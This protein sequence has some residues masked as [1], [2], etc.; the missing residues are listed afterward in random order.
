[1]ATPYQI[2]SGDTL[3]AIAQTNKTDLPTLL[4]LN[5]NIKDP[6]LIIA[7]QSLNLP[8]PVASPVTQQFTTPS[9]VVTSDPLRNAETLA[10]A[11][12]NKKMQEDQQELES[13]RMQS[14]MAALKASLGGPAPAAPNLEQN[15]T[16]L[17]NEK[18]ASGYSVQDYQKNITDLNAQ[19]ADAL[20]QL[21]K[22][23]EKIPQGVTE[24]FAQGSISVEQQAVQDKID[25]ID[26]QI[27]TASL[28]LQN[29]N[30][31]IETLMNLRQQDYATASK[32]YDREFSNNLAVYNALSARQDK[33]QSEEERAQDNARANLQIL[34]NQLSSGDLQFA[35]LD[36]AQQ[37]QINNL[38][39]QAGLPTG[40]IASIKD[41][42]P[43]ADIVSTTSRT[44]ASGNAFTDIILRDQNTGALTVQTISRGKERVPTKGGTTTDPNKIIDKFNDDLTDRNALNRAKT[45]E[46]FIRDLQAKYPQIHAGD[47][48]RKVYET[49]PDNY[50]K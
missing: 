19:K 2:K 49:Y 33:A 16:T 22:F 15:Y 11:E 40:T 42:N 21:Q 12:K 20:A 18:D 31:T 14:E 43:K 44:D 17:L 5:P 48:A 26:R 32:N 28:Q 7:G 41:N 50:D 13:L 9:S 39:L 34:A 8:D 37:A 6:N 25:F 24:G 46:Q 35:Q 36:P 47:I 45:R 10:T 23:K 38:E 4:K 27:N 1:M 30:S 29:R 3:S